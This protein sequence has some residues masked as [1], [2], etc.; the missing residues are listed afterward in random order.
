MKEG[1]NKSIKQLQNQSFDPLNPTAPLPAN[2]TRQIDEKLKTFDQ[3]NEKLVN[4]PWALTSFVLSGILFALA[5]AICL[6]IAFPVL[7][8]YWSKWLQIDPRLKR[9]KKEKLQL[10]TQ[11]QEVEK[12]LAEQIVQKNIF[13]NDLQLLPS[14][15]SLE[16]QK[17]IFWRKSKRLNVKLV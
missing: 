7:Q 8:C 4:S 12:D 5:G 10:V 3:L 16:I 2:V 15:E 14:F 17:K 1:V 9:L 11:L 13:E 6:G